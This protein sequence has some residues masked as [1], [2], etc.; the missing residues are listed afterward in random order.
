MNK[1]NVIKIG[2]NDWYLE[3]SDGLWFSVSKRPNIV[4]RFFTRIFTGYRYVS[5]EYVNKRGRELSGVKTVNE[6]STK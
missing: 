6:F 2:C 4:R 5:E 1:I 3:L